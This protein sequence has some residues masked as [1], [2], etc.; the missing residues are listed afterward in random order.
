[1][2]KNQIPTA[3]DFAIN[4]DIYFDSEEE[5]LELSN[6]LIEFAKLHVTEALKAADENSKVT[7]V[8]YEYELEPPTPIWGVDSNSILNAYP[9]D[10]IK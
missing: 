6:K 3:K 10:L 1:M 9:L 8:D 2:K 4:I 5:H 7:I